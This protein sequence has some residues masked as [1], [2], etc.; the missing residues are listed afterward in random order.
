MY[1]RHAFSA[2]SL[3]PGDIAPHLLCVSTW[4]LIPCEG[5][6]AARLQA[7]A[8]L[9]KS[10]ESQMM[11]RSHM[12]SFGC[13]H[14]HMGGEDGRVTNYACY[15]TSHHSSCL[16]HKERFISD[17]FGLSGTVRLHYMHIAAFSKQNDR[18]CSVNGTTS[19]HW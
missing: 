15:L 19:M 8:H 10:V 14:Q 3:L 16:R 6:S 4:A 12:S 2:A 11:T 13:Q 17:R 5:N 9:L 18:F 1:S 7:A